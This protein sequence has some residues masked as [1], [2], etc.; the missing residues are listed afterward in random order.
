MKA[1]TVVCIGYFLVCVGLLLYT[2]GCSEKAV[3]DHRP[4]PPDVVLYLSRV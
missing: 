2:I 1:D 3:G 4:V